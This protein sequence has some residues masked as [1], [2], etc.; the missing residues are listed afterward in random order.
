MSHALHGQHVRSLGTI[1]PCRRESGVEHAL[2]QLGEAAA[3]VHVLELVC[4][5]TRIPSVT[6]LPCGPR[7]GAGV[8]G[9]GGVCG[10]DSADATRGC[11][12]LNLRYQLDGPLV[13]LSAEKMECARSIW[14]NKM[15]I[16]KCTKAHICTYVHQSSSQKNTP[17]SQFGNNR[18]SFAQVRS[19]RGRP[20]QPGP[21][22]ALQQH[23]P[24]RL[25]ASQHRL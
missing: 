10:G 18:E 15:Q 7:G 4:S 11:S 14:P 2:L 19:V 13:N 23:E 20:Q 24:Q 16:K 3:N 25:L 12:F 9:G 6:H 22:V 1:D 21:R 17:S 8:G 5:H